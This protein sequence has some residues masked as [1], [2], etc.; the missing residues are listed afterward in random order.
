MNEGEIYSTKC[1]FTTKEITQINDFISYL[2][3][4]EEQRIKIR[5][6]TNV[7]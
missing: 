3:N 2:M 1:L 4:T 7:M 5:A 6:E